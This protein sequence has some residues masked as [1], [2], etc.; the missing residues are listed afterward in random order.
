MATITLNGTTYVALPPQGSTPDLSGDYI[1]SDVSSHVITDSSAGFIVAPFIASLYAD[2]SGTV[3]VVQQ[4]T[5]EILDI[6]RIFDLSLNAYESAKILNAFVVTD[7]DL[8]GT[9]DPSGHVSVTMAT[10][11][12]VVDF[13]AQL[14]AA[15]ADA[16]MKDASG[17]SLTNWLKEE[18]KAD[19]TSLLNFDT[20]AN[21]LEASVLSTFDIALDASG[22][23]DSMHTVM[24]ANEAEA[25]RRTLFTQLNESRV[26]AYCTVADPSGFATALER[27]KKINF[28]PM[29]AGDT[30]ALVFDVL[31]GDYT[32]GVGVNGNVPNVGANITRSIVDAA[33]TGTGSGANG[34]DSYVIGGNGFGYANGTITI[35]KPTMRRIAVQLHL[36][37]GGPAGQPISTVPSSSPNGDVQNGFELSALPTTALPTTAF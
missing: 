20:L 9:V 21:L 31:V 16:E 3:G 18:A 33:P 1:V 4:S 35:S 13:K 37:E 24:G 14:A 6:D 27:V 29:V 26:E 30:L 15:I 17:T 12:A 25:R 19:V 5:V 7:L 11:A 8:D 23:A 22:G 32:A 34:A 36:G 2:A 10:G 28:L